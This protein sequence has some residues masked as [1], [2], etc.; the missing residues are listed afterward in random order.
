MRSRPGTLLFLAAAVLSAA[1]CFSSTPPPAPARSH[2]A[3]SPPADPAAVAARISGDWQLAIERSGR[4][5]E[6]WLH[7][8]L[9]AGVLVGS[10]T[11][12]DANPR[13]I[14]KI[15]MK[16]DKIAFEVSGDARTEHYEGTVKGSSM[17]GTLKIGPPKGRQGEGGSGGRSGGGSGG[18]GYG[19]RRGGGGGRGGGGREGGSITWKA[20]RS[21]HAEPALEPTKA[22]ADAAKPSP[23]S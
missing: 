3:E 6:G 20:F 23:A 8:G 15:Q 4:T 9:T 13:E 10:V 12:P 5:L 11:G 16:G 21:V 19:G 2:E 14:S 1:A 17:E 18:G 22:P 7:F